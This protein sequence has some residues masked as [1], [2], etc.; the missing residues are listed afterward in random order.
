MEGFVPRDAKVVCSR[1]FGDCKDMASILTEMMQAAKIPAWFTWIG[2]RDLPYSFSSLPL[3]LVSNHMICTIQLKDQYIFLD[4][5]G[6]HLY[7]RI[8]NVLSS[9]TK[10]PCWLSVKKNIN[11]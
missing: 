10:K 9:R 3:P 1:R 11:C 8:S 6:S 2:S 7:I 4:A 5:H